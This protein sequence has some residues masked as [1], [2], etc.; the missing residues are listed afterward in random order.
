MSCLVK[1]RFSELEVLDPGAGIERGLE[2][3]RES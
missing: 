3:G 2:I 1:Q